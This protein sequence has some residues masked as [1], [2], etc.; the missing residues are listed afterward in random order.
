MILCC[1]VNANVL[2]GHYH[3]QSVRS[4]VVFWG[5]YWLSFHG[6]RLTARVD[7]PSVSE[8]CGHG[9]AT[10]GWPASSAE[11]STSSPSTAP[12]AD[13]ALS[14]TVQCWHYTLRIPGPVMTVFK[15]KT[16]LLFFSLRLQ[17]LLSAALQSAVRAAQQRGCGVPNRLWGPPSLLSDQHRGLFPRA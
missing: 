16:T 8:W 6:L 15:P 17:Y 7:W 10:Q 13:T 5:T 9:T 1:L 11:E 4:S 12:P 2:L 14:G 3:V